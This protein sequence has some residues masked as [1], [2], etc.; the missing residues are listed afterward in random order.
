MHTLMV[1]SVSSM[2]AR[3]LASWWKEVVMELLSAFKV[4]ITVDG[5]WDRVASLAAFSVSLFVC[6]KMPMVFSLMPSH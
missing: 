4:R 5:D 6:W 1:G 3:F 2:K